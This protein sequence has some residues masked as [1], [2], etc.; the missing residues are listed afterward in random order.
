L[1]SGEKFTLTEALQIAALL[2]CIF[3]VLYLIIAIK[4]K[5]LTIIPILYFISL[6]AGLI[7]RL[8]A[9]GAPVPMPLSF[10]LMFIDSFMPALS[11]LLILQLTFNKVPPP[12]F[13]GILAVP[14]IA[15]TPF[16][17]GAIRNPI[18]CTADIDLCFS[19]LSALRLNKAIVSS[20]IFILLT[21]IFARRS[22]ELEGDK[23][24][25]QHKYWLIICLII[26]NVILIGVELGSAGEFITAEKS[27]LAKTM[28]KIGFIY[29]IM[30]SIFR[31]FS[32]QFAPQE[33][34]SAAKAV[35][36]QYE[37]S[38]AARAERILKEEKIYRESGFNRA[39]FAKKL[40]VREHLLSRIINMH[41]N[42]S[43]SELAN[44]YRLD[45]AK[46]LLVSS[47]S[48]VT[49]IAYDVGFSS[50][51]SFNRVFKEL[52]GKSP[53]EYREMN[54]VNNT[55]KVNA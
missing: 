9:A 39:S 41:F 31:V 37:L 38:V 11:F 17:Y 14:A 15:I 51:T 20:F 47:Q 7:Y 48:P 24:I 1:F 54:I 21:S 10:I 35:L 16:V 23:I 42:K 44:E 52:T 53:S 49:T 18:L 50:I 45:E 27:H 29:M 12:I 19:S 33:S 5:K 26:Y 46:Q 36:S 22:A 40:G 28:I 13:W 43:F 4:N 34:V 30:T 2:P 55:G 8:L 32:D 6:S 25:V 3:I